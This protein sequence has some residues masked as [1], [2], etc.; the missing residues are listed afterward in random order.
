[1][2]VASSR[3]SE[4]C[5]TQT[6]FEPRLR[7]TRARGSSPGFRKDAKHLVFDAGWIGERANE[8]ENGSCAE[9]RPDQSR[10]AHRQMMC[11]RRHEADA[12][13]LDT[14]FDVTRRQVQAD[15]KRR[16]NI[17]SPGFRRGRPIAMFGDWNAACSGDQRGK[18]RDIE[19][20]MTIAAGAN[21]ID[22]PGALRPEAFSPHRNDRAGDFSHSLAAR[23]QRHQEAAE[24]GLGDT[25]RE[26]KLERGLRF[27][28]GQARSGR[29][30]GD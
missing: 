19:R 1:M 24:L 18:R 5:T 2:V 6:L 8:I 14:G 16:Q 29:G 13:L 4:P 9:F 28:L 7:K 15:A 27:G 17:A 23:P 25:S 10:M 30:L 11:P 20:P 12:R 22:R 3:P 26:N 21:D